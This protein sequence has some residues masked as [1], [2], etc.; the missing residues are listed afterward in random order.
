MN[1]DR[2]AT[3]EDLG[4][5]VRRAARG[6]RAAWERVVDEYVGLVWS[7]ARGLGLRENDAADVVQT[8][9]L[10]F[11][12]HVDELHD[13]SRAGAWLATTARRECWR[14]MAESRRT[15]LAGDGYLLD[16]AAPEQPPVD[17]R[18]VR[19]ERSTEL[20]RAVATL[21]DR[22]RDLM[23][24]LMVDPPLS[25]DDISR[26]LGVPHGS[27]GPTRARCLRRLRETMAD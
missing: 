5:L 4:E 21:P 20:H 22:W 26:R 25:Y 23:R 17:D 6:D 27:I 9:W 24:L 10:R 16:A 12:E 11:L 13:P 3:T 19:E 15:V 8:T 2:S 14:L 7:V 1:G 18:L